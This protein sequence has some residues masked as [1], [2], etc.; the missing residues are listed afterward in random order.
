VPTFAISQN[1]ENKWP[2]LLGLGAL[3]VVCGLFAIT[4]VGFSSL[5]SILYLG[6]LFMVTGVAEIIFA[7]RTRSDGHLWFHLLFGVLFAVAGWFIF[8]NPVANLIVLTLLIAT[9]LLA[10]GIVTL[11]GSV[12]EQFHN[13]GWF[14]LNGVISILAGFLIFRNPVESSFWLIGVLVG[15]EFLFRGFAWISLGWMGRSIEHAQNPPLRPAH[16]I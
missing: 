12:V 15:L 11:I 2:W 4:F 6:A 16:Q 3:M 13:W 5:V 10:T 8:M 9:V 14:A 1:L 7:I